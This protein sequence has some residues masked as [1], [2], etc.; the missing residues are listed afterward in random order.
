MAFGIRTKIGFSS[1]F[2]TPFA[3]YCSKKYEHDKATYIAKES[4]TI[5]PYPH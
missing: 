3:N 2:R 5:G 4:T 1:F